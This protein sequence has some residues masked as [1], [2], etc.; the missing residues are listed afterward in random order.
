MNRFL[1]LLLL[2]VCGCTRT[3]TRADLDTKTTENA[4]NSFADQTYYIGSKASYDYFVIEPGMGGPTHRYR[5]SEVAGAVTNRFDLT[6]DKSC[7]RG[8]GT[9]G[10]VITNAN[11]IIP[12]K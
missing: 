9:T 5:V 12:K 10:I 3:I 7:W 1:I 11:Q 8:Y 2:L 6:E 4:G